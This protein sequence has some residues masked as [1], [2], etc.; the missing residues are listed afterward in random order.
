MDDSNESEWDSWN[1]PSASD[2][3]T[4]YRLNQTCRI[5]H[6]SL[7]ASCPTIFSTCIRIRM[8]VCAVWDGSRDERDRGNR[9]AIIWFKQTAAISK[10]ENWFALPSSS[11]HSNEFHLVFSTI[12]FKHIFQFSEWICHRH[13]ASFLRFSSFH[14]FAP[15]NRRSWHQKMTEHI[16]KQKLISTMI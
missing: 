8:C 4:W 10:K 5:S 11:H 9:R 13:S 12:F 16:Q 6:R 1:Y 3:F 14:N 7:N 15:C 2:M